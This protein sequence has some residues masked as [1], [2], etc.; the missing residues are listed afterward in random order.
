VHVSKNIFG[1]D[2]VDRSWFCH[3]LILFCFLYAAVTERLGSL[4]TFTQRTHTCGDLTSAD[5]S[6]RVTVC[7]WLQHLRYSGMF[8]LL[9][10]AYG[11]VQAVITNPEVISECIIL[12]KI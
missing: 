6:S 9:R 4:S 12:L 3:T 5:V 8:M 7:G 11:A 1:L 10:D 2:P